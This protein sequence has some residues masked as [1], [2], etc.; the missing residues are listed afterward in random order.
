MRRLKKHDKCSFFRSQS[1]GHVDAHCA[2]KPCL[3]C[4]Q[5]SHMLADGPLRPDMV[6]S[7]LPSELLRDPQSLSFQRARSGSGSLRRSFHSLKPRPRSASPSMSQFKEKVTKVTG[8]LQDGGTRITSQLREG[9]S[10]SQA[11]AKLKESTM[12]AGSRR[13]SSPSR[14]QQFENNISQ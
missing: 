14:L 6:P 8:H 4:S 12:L 5:C 10:W 2:Y 11:G 7:N 9:A 13:A 1:H 3:P